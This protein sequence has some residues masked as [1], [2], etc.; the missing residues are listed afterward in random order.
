M[1]VKRRPLLNSKSFVRG[2]T[3]VVGP[4][5]QD[6]LGKKAEINKLERAKSV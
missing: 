4:I 2:E 5:E 1:N 3:L 6:L